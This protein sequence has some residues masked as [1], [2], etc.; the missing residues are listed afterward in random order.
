MKILFINNASSSDDRTSWSGTSYQMI[1][2]LKRL[3][4]CVD[5]LYALKYSK[6]TVLS[7]ILFSYW[8]FVA[9]VLHKNTRIDDS[10]YLMSEYR[11][12]LKKIDYS[13]YDFIIVPTHTCIMSALPSQINAK[14]I[15]LTDAVV[16]SL[17]DYYSEFSN[18][19]WHNYLEAHALGKKA[20]L[21]ANH[22]V[23]SSE[24]CKKNAIQSYGLSSSKV[25]VIEF[26]ANIDKDDILLRKYV[27]KQYTKHLKI[28]WSGVNWKRKGGDVA[29]ACCEEL[30]RLG[31]DVVFTVTGLDVLPKECYDTEGQLKPYI[32][33]CGFLCKNQNLEYKKL[34]NIMSNQ[35]IFLFP[36]RAECSSIAICEANGFGLPCFVYDTGGMENYVINEKNGYRLPLNSTG[37]VFAH[38]IKRCF[39]QGELEQMSMSAIEMYKHVLNWD[40]WGY[41]MKELMTTL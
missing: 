18:L 13:H 7:K 27:R 6:P 29:L 26:G 28:Y 41:K 24:W 40:V 9:V 22:I 37:K 21:R 31:F 12:T 16:D 3:G 36:S 39:E 23:V 19:I 10:L 8:K 17:F 34:V 14:V 1:Q 32:N 30:I 5:Y 20:F 15:F 25:S 2:S 35:D 11:K 4:F 33:S 38:I